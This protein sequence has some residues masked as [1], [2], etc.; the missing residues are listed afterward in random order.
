MGIGGLVEFGLAAGV[1][2]VG[3]LDGGG[4]GVVLAAGDGVD[5]AV[6]G[7]GE[8]DGKEVLEFLEEL[9]EGPVGEVVGKGD[10][11][12]GGT[13]DGVGDEGGG[14]EV[15]E[16]GVGVAGGGED[17]AQGAYEVGLWGEDG[18]RVEV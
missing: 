10:V 12:A 16:V 13:D 4:E 8:D 5:A 18:G 15:L 6:V 9:C 11:L 3:G 1:V 14:F 7:D 17:A 2:G